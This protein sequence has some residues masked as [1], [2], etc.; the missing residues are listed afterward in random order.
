MLPRHV[1]ECEYFSEYVVGAEA[2]HGRDGRPPGASRH[3]RGAER[4]AAGS[5]AGLAQR[6][7]RAGI[8]RRSG[9]VVYDGVIC[10]GA[11]ALVNAAHVSMGTSKALLRWWQHVLHAREAGLGCEVVYGWVSGSVGIGSTLLGDYEYE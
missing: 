2:V 9:T 4:G 5:G 1:T 7:A 8:R 11:G 3:R 10:V 6:S